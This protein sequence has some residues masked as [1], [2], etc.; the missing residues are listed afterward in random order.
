MIRK[1]STCDD[2][3]LYS[4]K[5][6]IINNLDIN[7]FRSRFCLYRDPPNLVRRGYY[8]MDEIF[9]ISAAVL[10]FLGGGVLI[11]GV[12]T[13]WLGDLWVKRLIHK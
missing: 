1:N 13:K 2:N 7:G 12:F 5:L 3:R 8:C 9:K 11:V 4:N 6:I 10:G